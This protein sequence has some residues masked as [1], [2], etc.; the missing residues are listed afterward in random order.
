MTTQLV[1]IL[2]TLL[3][4]MFILR[5]SLLRMFECT[6]RDR[7]VPEVRILCRTIFLPSEAPV[8]AKGSLNTSLPTG[9]LPQSSLKRNRDR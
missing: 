3:L 9:A 1:S 2:E 5:D 6:T 8:V 4:A 7:L